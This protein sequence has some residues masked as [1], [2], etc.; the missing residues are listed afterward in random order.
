MRSGA[1]GSGWFT[2]GRFEW[3]TR[4]MG[5]RW[6]K[7]YDIN[8]PVVVAKKSY[9]KGANGVHRMFA[10]VTSQHCGRRLFVI[11]LCL[12]GILGGVGCGSGAERATVSAKRSLTQGHVIRTSTAPGGSSLS[13]K[14]PCR[15]ASACVVSLRR[16]ETMQSRGES[17]FRRFGHAATHEQYFAVERA[18]RD[19]YHALAAGRFHLACGML[20]KAYRRE[21]RQPTRPGS[22]RVMSCSAFLSAAFAGGREIGPTSAQLTIRK[23]LQARVRGRRGYVLLTTAPEPQEVGVMTLYYEDGHWRMAVFEAPPISYSSLAAG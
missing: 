14:G 12:L 17:A 19:Y 23:V 6:R 8:A 9:D 18:L 2:K 5:Q 4:P 7:G 10:L 16:G 21:L 22:R 11:G 13:G 3:S 20:S 1:A 15:H